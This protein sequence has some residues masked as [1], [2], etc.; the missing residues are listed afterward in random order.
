MTD[1]E[2]I[3][4][5]QKQLDSHNHDYHIL[6]EKYMFMKREN[7]L[8]RDLLKSKEQ[9]NKLLKRVLDQLA[10]KQIINDLIGGDE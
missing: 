6:N 3:D 8:L 5:L 9:E 4:C 10:T 1:Q 2:K 7:I